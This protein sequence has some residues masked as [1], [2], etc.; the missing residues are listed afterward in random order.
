MKT[1]TTFVYNLLAAVALLLCSMQGFSQECVSC[2]TLMKNIR[3]GFNNTVN[4]SWEEQ[5]ILGN[6]NITG[7]NNAVAIG[8]NSTASWSHS[9]VFGSSSSSNGIHSYAIGSNAIAQSTY[10]YAFGQSAKSMFGNA[11]SVGNFT[12]SD[13][14]GAYVFGLG[15][16]SAIPFVN[17]VENSLAVGFLST[18]PTLFV[19]ESPS[20]ANY[21]RTGRVGI[22][23][24]TDPQAKL[25]IRADANE[26]ATLRLEATGSDKHAR[27]NFTDAHQILASANDHM[28]FHT[29]EGKGYI[30]H[31]GD[32]Y[33]SDIQSGIIMKSPNGQCWRGVLSDNGQ[34]V[35]SVV[36][37]PDGSANVPE[38]SI[39]PAL[40]MKIYPNPTDGTITIEVPDGVTNAGWSLRSTDGALLMRNRITSGKTEISLAHFVA[41]VYLITIEQKGRL[42]ASEKVVKQ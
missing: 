21:D 12:I 34:L 29:A 30:F 14:V 24:V 18:K 7:R 16:S 33:I 42:I 17:D 23:N 35:F 2:D 19:S 31:G 3:L 4:N 25:H 13:A 8:T 26:H 10:S 20:N 6:N 38:P 36:T 11:F 22:G 9:Y 27:I 32:I 40:Q 28:H 41:G 5:T 1:T 39:E 37:C 15:V